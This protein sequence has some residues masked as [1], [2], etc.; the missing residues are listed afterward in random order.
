MIQLSNASNVLDPLS[1]CLFKLLDEI[2]ILHSIFKIIG[3]HFTALSFAF[4]IFCFD[5][6][7][8]DK[9]NF[10]NYNILLTLHEMD[11]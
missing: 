11:F 5:F 1:Y 9:F 7:I 10:W 6:R 8:M 2:W 3:R 4:I